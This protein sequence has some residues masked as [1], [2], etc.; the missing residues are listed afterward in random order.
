MKPRQPDVLGVFLVCTS[1]GA[2][3]GRLAK[4]VLSLA[5]V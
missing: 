3:S 1:C 5:D 2:N 4:A